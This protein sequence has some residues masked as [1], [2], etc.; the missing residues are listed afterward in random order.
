MEKDWTQLI[1]EKVK[2]REFLKLSA[3]AIAA[4]GMPLAGAG[5][6][7]ATGA[8]SPRR[9]K[10]I[11]PTV[12]SKNR[13]IVHSVCLGCNARCGVRAIV[14]GGKLV[15]H[16]GNPYHP[17]NTQFQPIDYNT[18]VAESLAATGTICG[19]AEEG[20]N[21]LYNPYRLLKPLKRS[22]KRGS[23]KFEPIEW[24]QLIDEV[25]K[26]GK[27]FAR[28]GDM[29]E[30]PG[31]ASLD[32]DQPINPDA[33]ELGSVR[34]GF[35]FLSGRDQ[36]GR[37]EFA[38][39]FVRDAFGSI[40]RIGHTDICGI[41]FRMGNWA[42]TEKKEVEF[43]AD[44]LNAEFMLVLGANIYEATQP[45]VNTYGAMV[46]RR[47][48]EG[49][50]SFV[51]VDPRATNASVHA[52]K[53]IA[54]KPGQDGALAMGMIRWIIENERYNRGF[55]L[56]PNANSAAAQ[57]YAC[58]SNATHLVIT[59][60][61]HPN[62]RKLLR[63]ADIDPGVPQ[64]QANAFMVLVDG[65]RPVPFDKAGTALLDFAGEVV[66][67]AGASIK[68]KTS[69]RL[70]AEAAQLHSLEEYAGLAGVPVS[71]IIDIAK[72]FTSH[73]TRAAVTQY[74]GVGNYL[75]G[76]HAA[77]AVAVLNA[78]VG[79]VDRKG[80][81]LKGG[82]GAA[83]WNKGLYDLTD[84]PG[85]RKPAGVMI[86]REK[87]A[88]E[89]TTEFKRHGYP[90]KRPWFPFTVGG[91]CV[92]AMS[93]IDEQY[94]YPCKI[95]FT[96]FFNPVYS[97]P[98]G[99]RYEATLAD[100]KKVPLHVSIDVTVNESNLYADYIVPDLTY[101]EG[102]YGFLTPHAPALRFTAVRVPT[103]EPLTAKTADGQAYSLEAFLI[104][105]AKAAGLPG[106]GAGTV[107]GAQAAYGLDSGEDYYLRGIAN[108]AANA[109]V[110]AASQDEIAFVE[111]NYPT[112]RYKHLL[113]PEEWAKC[114]YLLARGGVFQQSYEDVFAGE[115]HRF[116]V[117]KVVL[118]ND[119]LA[120]QRN[121]L[122]GEYCSGVAAYTVATTPT[123]EVL[124][125]EDAEYG[126]N[127][128]TYKMNVHAQART[129]W[130]KWAM[131]IFPENY[132]LM[133]ERDAAR[134][135]LSTGNKVRLIS[136]SN[137]QGITG[138]IK[139]TKLVRTGCLAI[140]HH[141]GHTMMGAAPLSV[142]N[143]NQV[144]FGGNAVADKKKL[145]PDMT[146]GRGINANNISRLDRRLNNTPLTDAV[147]GIPD[148][149]STKVKIEVVSRTAD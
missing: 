54:I 92:E 49:E 80:G 84:F 57:G 111:A 47:N 65:N 15:K 123:G 93:G 101:P 116:G 70:L 86:S 29:T 144:F 125:E 12:K 113:K 9:F 46:A 7:E 3:A 87:A 136:R 103:V 129:V 146:I 83:A 147:G 56:S 85:K 98:G 114:C 108:L 77:Y 1:H 90:S 106:F 124:A 14:Q 107:P 62:H 119:E 132:I 5:A 135:K 96:Y 102:H 149:S 78:L 76:T 4:A 45:G 28:L 133:N 27:V 115:N 18:P 122:T 79:S 75:G 68:V 143:A 59:D 38:D 34:N 69:F 23:G 142:T 35:I 131:E 112:A 21:Y 22:G 6:A 88:Y 8:S 20:A 42:L 72:E 148:F 39:R 81:Y 95:L 11:A 134:E 117:K 128:V 109:K 61:S 53:W 139:V 40:N 37:K 67:A 118:Y 41:G 120:T 13:N 52:K 44:P 26:G 32:S 33:P 97:I 36:T 31:L 63:A 141:Y 71:Q 130:H 99:N 137:T 58:H 74:H 64:D 94:P 89:K 110:P 10:K 138:K 50:L 121:S 60:P 82:G 30:Y 17:Y 48:S 140:A 127:M 16:A 145:K 91:L 66:T 100:H 43:K 51:V 2:R 126:Y 104:D 55:L 25:A 19:K 105:L 24:E 73:G